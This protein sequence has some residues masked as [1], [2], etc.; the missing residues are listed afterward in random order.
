MIPACYEA[1][2]GNS[3]GYFFSLLLFLW[4]RGFYLAT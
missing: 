3:L 1:P 2:V 4:V